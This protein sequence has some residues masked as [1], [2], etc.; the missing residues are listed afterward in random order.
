MDRGGVDTE[1]LQRAGH[2]VAQ[3]L[4][5]AEHEQLGDALPDRRDHAVLVH[6]V[7]RQEHV[8]HR[9]HRVG[10]GVDRHLDRIAQVVTDEVADV[11]VERGREQHRLAPGDAVAQDPLDLRREPVVGH[12]VGLVEDDDLHRAE[13]HLVRLDEVDQPQRRGHDDLDAEAQLL[14]LVGPA[15]PAVH[16]EHALAGVGG[17]RLEHL[18]DLDRQ[19][20]RRDEHEAE[21]P[22]GGGDLGDPGHHRHAEGERLARSGA[23][24]PAD[25]AALHRHGDGRGLDHE[26]L[27]EPH[28]GQPGVD[29]FGHAECGEAGRRVDGR[30]R[31]RGGEVGGPSA[32]RVVTVAGDCRSGSVG[33]PARSPAAGGSPPMSSI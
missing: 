16:G 21:R 22:S 32:D 28:R 7:H 33:V 11:A 19:L 5:L 18:G 1:I 29:A 30:Q 14:D 20:T 3:A 9:A 23:G 26:R 10:G 13:A 2:L 15:G 6:V 25:V 8:V 27:G 12:A 17:D 24:A 4:G 31:R